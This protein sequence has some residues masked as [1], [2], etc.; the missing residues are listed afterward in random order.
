MTG[1]NGQADH[2]T[3][4][5]T[6]RE[7]LNQLLLSYESQLEQHVRMQRELDG[8]EVTA[9][10]E[11][12]QVTVGVDAAGVMTTLDLGWEAFGRYTPAQLA[13]AIMDTAGHA[14]RQALEQIEQL[15][16]RRALE[17]DRIHGDAKPVA[18]P[19]EI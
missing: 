8:F 2:L 18:V 7:G 12:K 9:V 17:T 3:G 14:H 6:L 19:T 13:V 5:Q 11:D 16:A 10:S 1:R 4:Y 15:P